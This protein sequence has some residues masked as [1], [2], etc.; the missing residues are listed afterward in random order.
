LQEVRALVSPT[1]TSTKWIPPRAAFGLPIVVKFVD[2]RALLPGIDSPADATIGLERP[3]D[4]WMSPL[5]LRPIACSDGKHIP[6][7]L[8]FATRPDSITVDGKPVYLKVGKA[9]PG[10]TGPIASDGWMA[11]GSGDAARAFFE[12]LSVD[13]S[14]WRRP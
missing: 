9:Q 8:L 4:R 5:R 13:R 1:P 6:V 10:P 3:G 2:D 12:W 14:F 7:M 11:R